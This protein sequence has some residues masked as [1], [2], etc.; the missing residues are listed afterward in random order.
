MLLKIKKNV[1]CI[2]NVKENDKLDVKVGLQDEDKT[3]VFKDVDTTDVKSG[4]FFK[5]R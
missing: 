1:L 2:H 5:R 4:C 3:F